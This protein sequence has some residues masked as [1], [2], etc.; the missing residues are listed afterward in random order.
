MGCGGGLVM[1][2]EAKLHISYNKLRA[3][4]V[5]REGSFG[6]GDACVRQAVPWPLPL[7]GSSG[8]CA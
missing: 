6:R 8:L 7:C 1:M 5:I 3:R 2:E 4:G